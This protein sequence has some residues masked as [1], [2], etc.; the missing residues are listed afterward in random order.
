MDALLGRDGIEP[1]R[2]FRASG[3]ASLQRQ[4]VLLN[5][6]GERDEQVLGFVDPAS[7]ALHEARNFGEARPSA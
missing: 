4:E 5:Q 2:P 1:D 6:T 7:G 3:F